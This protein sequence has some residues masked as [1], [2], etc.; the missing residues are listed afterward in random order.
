MKNKQSYFFIIVL[1]LFFITACQKN[2][3][4]IKA[5]TVT[6]GTI[7][8]ISTTNDWYIVTIDG[9]QMGDSLGGANLSNIFV[10]KKEGPQRM[11]ITNKKDHSVLLDTMIVLTAPS[12]QFVLLELSPGEKPQLFSNH[13]N[14]PAP[15]EDSLKMRF[16]YTDP[17]LPESIKMRFYY[18]D[19]NTFAYE[20]FDSVVL[21]KKEIGPYVAAH[22]TKY[23][24]GYGNT[25]LGYDILSTASNEIIQ[26]LDMDPSSPR[27]AEGV[28]FNIIYSNGRPITKKATVLL[29]IGQ[30]GAMEDT[31]IDRYLFGSD[32]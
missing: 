3:E 6:L 14:E 20:A 26:P 5:P 30:N 17:K 29:R 10:E 28:M 32:Q 24:G 31:Y 2:G 1:G 18:V 16:M 21:H 13:D 12:F 27:F 4:L 15:G 7:T 8:S 19:A 25:F 22:L 23:P 9:S 11:V